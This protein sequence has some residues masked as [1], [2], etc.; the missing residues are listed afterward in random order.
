MCL[1][2]TLVDT[3]Y[4][5]RIFAR[6]ASDDRQFLVYAMQVTAAAD[7]AMVLPL[8]VPPGCPEDAVRFIDLEGYTGLFEDMDRAFP[9]LLSAGVARGNSMPDTV[10]FQTLAVHDVGAFEAS[11]V[12]SPAD[13]GRLD[14]RF[15]L[16]T[17]VLEMLGALAASGET[18]AGPGPNRLDD[19][20]DYGF[21]VF[22][23]RGLG[24]KR[25]W[26]DRLLGR[27]PQPTS[28]DFHPMAFEFPRRDPTSL[29]F[30]T[31]HVHDGRVEPTAGFDHTLYCQADPGLEDAL[32][33]WTRS[34][35]PASRWV[36]VPSSQGTVAPDLPLRRLSVMGYQPNLDTW[37]GPRFAV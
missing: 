7:V 29:F 3:V 28:L 4:G 12:P 20:G 32:A 30:P 33:G 14:P 19:Y 17:D 11:F 16:D 22:Q 36:D 13:F 15:R 1:F 9:V 5:T 23:L 10:V 6:A 31:V 37:I 18:R 25:G 27:A 26:L 2:T 8:P 35:G 21:A 34:D 24:R